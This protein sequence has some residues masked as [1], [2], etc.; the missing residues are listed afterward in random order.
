M[1]VQILLEV[2]QIAEI[3]VCHGPNSPI[4]FHWGDGENLQIRFLRLPEFHSTAH[5]SLR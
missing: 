2:G 4:I 5:W 1:P 3:V